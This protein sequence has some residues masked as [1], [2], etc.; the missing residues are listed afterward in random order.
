M[1]EN[2]SRV[3]GYTRM[4]AHEVLN[5]IGGIS[6]VF[7]HDKYR[8]NVQR[9]IFEPI[10]YIML[11]ID[12]IINKSNFGICGNSEVTHIQTILNLITTVMNNQGTKNQNYRQDSSKY[13]EE[14][15]ASRLYQYQ[16]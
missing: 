3:A 7:R 4:I 14:S 5:L 11:S 12:E 13:V 16:N 6:N 2:I 1:M 9:N 15:E 8:R 10:M